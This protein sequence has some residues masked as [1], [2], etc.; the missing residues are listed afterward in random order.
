MLNFANFSL[1]GFVVTM[2]NFLFGCEKETIIMKKKVVVVGGGVGGSAVAKKLEQVAD[3]TLIDPKEYFEVPYAQMRC[4]VEPSFAKRSIIKHSEYLKTARVVQSAARGISGSEVITASGDHV[5]F[6]Y[7]VITTGTTYSGPSTRA[8]LIKLYEDENTKLLAANSVLV[9]GGGPVGVELVAEI[10]VDFPDKKVTL[11]HSGDRLLQFLGPKAS[12]KTLNWLR[13]K[14]V[15]VSLNDRVEIQGMPGPQYVTKNG[16]HILAEYLKIC[17][18]KHVGSSWLRDSDLRQLIDSDGRLK[19]DRHLRLEGKSNIFAV[20]DIVNT[21]EIKQGFLA[22]K[23]AGVVADNIKRLI[24]APTQPKLAEYEPLST[25]FGIVSLGR[26]EGVA[27]LPIVP[28]LPILGRLPG[29]L[30]SKDLF[31]TKTRA[32]LGVSG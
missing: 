31:V 14:N 25:P 23:Q 10:L 29:M 1:V 6:D 27:Q 15:E 7:L 18:G 13:S 4:I 24:Q 16:A 12:Q 3:V 20:G 9:I 22:N 30:K 26:Y 8:E 17:V 5:E 11:V 2:L 19:V 28:Q 21:K 32:E